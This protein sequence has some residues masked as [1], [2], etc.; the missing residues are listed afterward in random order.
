MKS[1]LTTFLIASAFASLAFA[2]Q[3]SPG[4]AEQQ[5]T[6]KLP[7]FAVVDNN[8]DGK[9]DMAEAKKLSDSLKDAKSDITFDF[10][11]AD[12]NADG[13]VDRAEYQKYEQDMNS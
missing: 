9:I 6:K 12:A 5:A 11:T 8:E 3:Q 2:Q 4:Q 7:D 10:K 13:S 1:Q